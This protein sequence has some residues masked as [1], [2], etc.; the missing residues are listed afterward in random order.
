MNHRTWALSYR[1]LLILAFFVTA[2]EASAVASSGIQPLDVELDKSA[3][4]VPANVTYEW[5]QAGLEVSGRIEKSRS[6]YGRIL[7]HAEI[8]LLD[9]QGR[10]LS[11]HRGALQHF[12]PRRK[13]PDW[14]SFHEVVKVVPP[15]TVK[16]RICHAMG[17]RSCPQ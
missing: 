8:E 7:G 15:E 6:H 3:P 9:A 4:L 12:N 14:A 11:R 2:S 17:S 16:L 10:V 13:D 1:S 5:T